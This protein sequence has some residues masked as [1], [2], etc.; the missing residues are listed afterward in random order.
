MDLQFVGIQGPPGLE[1]NLVSLKQKEAAQIVNGIEHRVAAS[2][3]ARILLH[4][5]LFAAYL[6]KP[7][8]VLST[9]DT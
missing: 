5:L 4:A 8:C 2:Q 6:D 3:T 7:F 9:N 1:Y